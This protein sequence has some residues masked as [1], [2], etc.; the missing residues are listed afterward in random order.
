[1]TGERICFEEYRKRL[2]IYRLEF[3]KRSTW[4]EEAKK[5]YCRICPDADPASVYVLWDEY[6]NSLNNPLKQGDVSSEGWKMKF[7]MEV[8]RLAT[9]DEFE[10]QLAEFCDLARKTWE[11]ERTDLVRLDYLRDRRGKK[12]PFKKWDRLLTV[13]DARRAHPGISLLT[14]G[15]MLKKKGLYVC[16]DECLE[17]R[18]C[19]D[20]R[21]V[22]RLILASQKKTFP[23]NPI[24]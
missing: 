14:L 4:E 17:E 2:E 24:G 22:E 9:I 8:S 12:I 1:M 13:Y 19:E 15:K 11:R 3:L 5:E 20:T 10:T 16:A 23:D 21:E 7:I 6:V 18:I